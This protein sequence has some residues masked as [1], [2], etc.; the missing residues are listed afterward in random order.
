MDSKT[1]TALIAIDLRIPGTG[2]A[3]TGPLITIIGIDRPGAQGDADRS[4]GPDGTSRDRRRR[5][6]VRSKE[7]AR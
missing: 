5:A 7:V 1:T 2:R 3:W 4:I 6:S